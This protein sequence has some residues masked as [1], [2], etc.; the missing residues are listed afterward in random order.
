MREICF[1]LSQDHN[2]PIYCFGGYEGEHNATQIKVILPKRMLPEGSVHYRFVFETPRQDQVFSGPIGAEDGAVTI[3]I[4]QELMLAPRLQLSVACYR[5]EDETLTM[6]AKSQK[7][8]LSIQDACREDGETWKENAISG[9][10]IPI[11]DEVLP[12]RKCL[13]WNGAVWEALSDKLDKRDYVISASLE[14]AGANPVTGEAIQRALDEK[15]DKRDYVISPSLEGAGANPVTGEAVQRA[16]DEKADRDE[17]PFASEL[18][19]ALKRSAAGNTLKIT[20]ASALK[21]PFEVWIEQGKIPSKNLFQ[22]T[23]ERDLFA[24]VGLLAPAGT[25]EIGW[26]CAEDIQWDTN[27][28]LNDSLSYLPAGT[29]TLS[30]TESSGNW[31]TE[32]LALTLG[33]NEEYYY[34]FPLTFTITE[35]NAY[36]E[37]NRMIFSLTRYGINEGESGTVMIQ[38]E[39]GETATEYVPCGTELSPLGDLFVTG[40]NLFDRNAV[41]NNAQLVTGKDETMAMTTFVVSD[42]IMI[43]PNTTFI[44]NRINRCAFYDKNKVFL[45]DIG[46]QEYTATRRLVTNE[47]EWYIRFSY[48]K[49]IS[50]GSD[51]QIE[52]GSNLSEYEPFRTLAKYTPSEDGTVEGVMSLYPS[53]T[54]YTSSGNAILHAKYNQDINKVIANIYSKIQS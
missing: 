10:V 53:M 14:E 7:M 2:H 47:N 22:I 51:V 54:L 40:K 34:K 17:L 50:D 15:L 16:L 19:G 39:K 36:S 18:A 1:D 8:V 20:D 33:G 23:E 6:L 12:D 52:L 42:Y 45:R 24:E 3:C 41:T 37:D 11:D 31:Y 32:Y 43:P 49:S 4:P 13:V 38:I 46:Y 28:E 25:S 26:S 5:F 9:T 21:A 44:G 35:E 30:I 48:A 29:Y 27:I